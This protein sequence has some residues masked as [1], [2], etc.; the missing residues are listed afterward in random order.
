MTLN[1]GDINEI[2]A[3]M[4][5]HKKVLARYK[6]RR[7]DFIDPEA[8]QLKNLGWFMVN[9]HSNL[10]RIWQLVSVCV[11]VVVAVGGRG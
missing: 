7:V 11:V 5:R 9:P 10:F 8:V 2:Q 6:I 1:Q 3:N 4:D